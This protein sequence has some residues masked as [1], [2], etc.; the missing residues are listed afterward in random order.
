M[1]EGIRRPGGSAFYSALQAARLGKRALV[2][3]RG[4]GTEI[5]QL[6]APYSGE[7]ELELEQA[8]CTTSLHTEGKGRGRVQHLLSWAGEMGVEPH[9]DTKVLHIAPIARETPSSWRG[10][11]ELAGLT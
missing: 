3:T 9:V 4:A 6:L 11:V 10:A 7:L 5:E 2:I 1:P 8:P